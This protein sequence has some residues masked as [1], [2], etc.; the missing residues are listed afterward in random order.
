MWLYCKY[1]FFFLRKNMEGM[2]LYIVI[3]VIIIIIISYFAMKE[4]YTS[5]NDTSYDNNPLN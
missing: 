2:V 4:S 1:N 5:V 3:F